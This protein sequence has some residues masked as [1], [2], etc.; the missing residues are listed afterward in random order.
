F[1]SLERFIG[2]LIENYAGKF[3]LWLAP[4][5]VVVATITSDADAYAQEVKAALA[6]AGL[7]TELDIRNE[8]I[9]YKVREHSLAKIPA[10]LAVGKKEAESHTVSV[11]R[12]GHEGQ[13]VMATDEALAALVDEATPPDIKR[14]RMAAADTAAVT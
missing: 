13:K 5:Q 9:N 1:G 8:K 3:P 4:L 7:R 11:R 14:A 6:A 2:V 10:L 12:F